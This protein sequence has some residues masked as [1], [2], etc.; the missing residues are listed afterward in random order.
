MSKKGKPF[1]V[2]TRPTKEAVV[3]S[4]TR[5]ISVDACLFDLIDNSVDAARD[6]IFARGKKHPIDGLPNS[7]AGY[8]ISLS[9]AGS[10]FSIRDKCGGITVERLKELVLRFGKRSSHHMGIGIFGL[11]LNRAL[12]KL[13]RVS[14]LKTDTAS[15]RAE[16]VLN[17]E[18]YLKS[19]DWSLPAEEF[20]SSGQAGT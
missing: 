17:T 6:S 7:Y 8:K 18:E 4:L 19:D 1:S 20:Q 3:D 14:H 9:F 15:Q 11:G 2:D 10:G 16:L 13:G 12:F 5:D